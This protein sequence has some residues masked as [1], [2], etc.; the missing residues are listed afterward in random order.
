VNAELETGI[1]SS[2]AGIRAASS[3]PSI[4][5]PFAPS[6]HLAALGL[7]KVCAAASGVSSDFSKLA[8]AAAYGDRMDRGSV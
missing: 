2:A 1:L 5:P 7:G 6:L 4:S 3:A 8:D